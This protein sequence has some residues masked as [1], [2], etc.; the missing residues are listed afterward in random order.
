MKYPMGR[1]SAFVHSDNGREL[2]QMLDRRNRFRI[3]G[4]QIEITIAHRKDGSATTAHQSARAAEKI[5][6]E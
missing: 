3:S 4:M 1:H 5:G 6:A 2:H